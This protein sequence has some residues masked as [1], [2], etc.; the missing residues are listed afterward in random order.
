[1]GVALKDQGKLE[2]AIKA[3]N[4]ALAIK[5]DYAEAHLGLNNAQKQLV[6]AWHLEMMND[7]NRNRAYLDAIK[8]AVTEDDFVLEIGTGSG[9]LAMMAAESGS[10]Q[11]ITCESS[12]TISQVAK[13][14]ISENNYDDVIEVI[15]KKSTELIV[16][17]D[18]PRKADV[19]ISEVLSAEFVGEGVQTTILDANKRLLRKNGKMLP[20]SGDIR[21]ALLG[22]EAEINGNVT[23]NNVCGFD[24]SK[25]NLISGNKFIPKLKNK[26]SLLSET[27]IAFKLNLHGSDR[28]IKEQKILNLTVQKSGTC[29]GVIQWLGIQIFKDIEYQNKPGEIIS[30]WPTPIYMFDS[31]KAVI[32]G[33]VIKIRASLVKDAIWFQYIE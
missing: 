7:S 20:E 9:L 15:N 32:A 6:P 4:K 14:I 5:P 10:K 22:D 17:K 26:P 13:K 2:E 25:F 21:I 27:E 12:K 24:L 31:P 11:I 8:L 33:D 3:Y 19:I 16:G 28:I 18:L 1:M 29:L 30:H 23:V